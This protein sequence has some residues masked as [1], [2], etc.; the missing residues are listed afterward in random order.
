MIKSLYKFDPNK[1]IELVETSKIEGCECEE[2]FIEEWDDI[3][4]LGQEMIKL[5]VDKGGLGLAAPQVGVMKKMFVWMNGTN[6]FQIVINPSFFPEKKITNLV[7]G[8]LSYPGSH[9]YLQRYKSGN[10]RF[11]I[12]DPKDNSK[13]KKVFRKVSGERSF[14]FQHELD[15]INGITIA[16][17]GKPF[18]IGENN[19]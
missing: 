17:K 8:C 5:C 7:E 16:M 2:V 4:L 14:V 15:H 12:L 19:A 11:E 18:Q 13:F 6:S 10:I 3:K 1:Q 9:F